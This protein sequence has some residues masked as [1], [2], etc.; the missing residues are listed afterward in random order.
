MFYGF[1]ELVAGYRW[2]S[3]EIFVSIK[4]HKHIDGRTPQK[5]TFSIKYLPHKKQLTV[6]KQQSS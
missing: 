6:K 5:T 3:T 1:S 4:E 2:I